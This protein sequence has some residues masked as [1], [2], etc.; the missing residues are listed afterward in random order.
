MEF[1]NMDALEQ[2]ISA[3]QYNP[4]GSEEDDD[5][6]VEMI[7]I[8]TPQVEIESHASVDITNFENQQKINVEEIKNM[9]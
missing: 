7:S 2:D 1:Q 3:D 4:Y 6:K 9:P 5:S 8:A